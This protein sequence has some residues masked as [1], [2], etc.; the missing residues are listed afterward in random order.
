MFTIFYFIQNII[1][2]IKCRTF[3]YLSRYFIN[4]H[5][6]RSFTSLSFTSNLYTF[7]LNL[8]VTQDILEHYF[9]IKMFSRLMYIS[10][11]MLNCCFMVKRYLKYRIYLIFFMGILLEIVIHFMCMLKF[12]NT[13]FT[14]LTYRLIDY[15]N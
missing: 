4:C 8:N 7:M 11:V 9:T 5:H 3:K 10:N 13:F 15:M 14:L 12:K 1:C 6:T 2:D